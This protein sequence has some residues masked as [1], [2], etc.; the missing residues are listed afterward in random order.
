[1]YKK[2]LE[3]FLQ[4]GGIQDN[5]DY[6]IVIN[7][8]CTV[9][10]PKLP[11]IQVI[12][13]ENKGFDFGAWQHV[14]KNYINRSYEYYIF[15]NSSVIGPYPKNDPTWLQKFL[16]LF[17]TGPDVKLVGTSINILE[18]HDSIEKMT[19]RYQKPPPYSHVQSMFF[20]LNQEGYD[21]LN[22]IGFFDDE[23]TL[24]QQTD[25]EYFILNKEIWMSQHIL[26]NNWNIN[27]ILPKYRDL[28]YRKITEN[29]N[30]SSQDP[31]YPGG[32]FGA[33]IKPENVVFYKSYRFV[34]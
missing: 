23:E 28:D 4:N 2:N 8:K 30:P 34:E 9:D 1:M 15:L 24:N 31:Q 17:R 33:T 20:V 21:Y 10:I 13:K 6:Y 14:I 18:A 7:G 29:I 3:Y 26:K 32:Y 22:E 27:C 12:Q 19:E 25:I 16:D 11:N 5:I